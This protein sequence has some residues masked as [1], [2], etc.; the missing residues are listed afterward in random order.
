MPAKYITKKYKIVEQDG[1]YGLLRIRENSEDEVILKPIYSSLEVT[2]EDKP[3]SKSEIQH[4][5]NDPTLVSIVEYNFPII[6]ADKKCSLLDVGDFYRFTNKY[7]HIVKLSFDHY[8]FQNQK[9]CF[10]YEIGN[11]NKPIA[12]FI[13]FEPLSLERLFQILEE[14]Y[15]KAHLSLQKRVSGREY[16]IS[17]YRR[18]LGYHWITELRYHHPIVIA[19]KTEVFRNNLIVEDIV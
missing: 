2:N 11:F 19:T 5:I 8:L 14:R 6:I 12:K 15:P 3:L 9:T 4:H 16:Y 1:K 13:E 17:Q 10:L 7:D 18:Y